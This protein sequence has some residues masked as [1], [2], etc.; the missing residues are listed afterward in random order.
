MKIRLTSW[1]IFFMTCRFQFKFL[2]IAEK[3]IIRYQSVNWQTFSSNL[4]YETNDLAI[5]FASR[6][7]WNNSPGPLKVI[8]CCKVKSKVPQSPD[9]RSRQVYDTLKI[10]LQQKV[11][12]K[13]F[14]FR[15]KQILWPY[16]LF[17]F[18]PSVTNLRVRCILFEISWM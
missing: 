4:L 3:L 1:M 5:V 15:N 2:L 13:S 11:S 6:I 18:S 8:S 17:F 14:H 16:F 10:S 7:P 12:S 9:K